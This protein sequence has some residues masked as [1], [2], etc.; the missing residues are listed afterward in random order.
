MTLRSTHSVPSSCCWSSSM[1]L[2]SAPL[3]TMASFPAGVF[4]H[5]IRRST[6]AH[7]RRRS[8]SLPTAWTLLTSQARAWVQGFSRLAMASHTA[9]SSHSSPIAYSTVSCRTCPVT[10]IC[11]SRSTAPFCKKRC[12]SPILFTS[13][14]SARTALLWI[15]VEP[16]ES[17]GITQS[18]RPC[19]CSSL[20]ASGMHTMLLSALTPRSTSCPF[21]RT[22]SPTTGISAPAFTRCGSNWRRVERSETTVAADSCVCVRVELRSDTRC[23]RKLACTTISCSASSHDRLQRTLTTPSSSAWF[24]RSWCLSIAPTAPAPTANGATRSSRVTLI[25][26]LIALMRTWE[27]LLCMDWTRVGRSARSW[28]SREARLLLICSSCSSADSLSST[29]PLD[30]IPSSIGTPP[31][32][33]SLCPPSSPSRST[34]TSTCIA[35]CRASASGCPLLAWT[36]ADS[37]PL[38]MKRWRTGSSSQRIVSACIADTAPFSA[39]IP[40]SRRTVVS[41]TCTLA[42]SIA[43]ARLP[44]A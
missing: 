4:T 7:L 41:S 39:S 34:R 25:S 29:R 42:A 36:S 14:P 11:A 1:E 3:S 6:K 8:S 27:R 32:S 40:T 13:A 2:V 12:R 38:W 19:F 43:L 15:A 16:T 31:S 23:G 33:T 35:F 20:A 28:P 21:P 9:S 18:T 22:S 24:L 26:T 10:S 17:S 5:A 37:T 44:S 30:A